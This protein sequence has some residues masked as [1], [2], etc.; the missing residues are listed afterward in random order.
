MNT[1]S[2]FVIGKS[3]RVCQDYSSYGPNFIVVSDGCSGSQDTDFGSRIIAKTFSDYSFNNEIYD[4]DKLI[5][6]CEKKVKLLNLAPMSLDA[7]LLAAYVKDGICTVD[8]YGDGVLVKQ[9]L[10]NTFEVT[11]INY[12][13]D[14]PLYPSYYLNKDRLTGYVELFG[15][16][17]IVKKY[18]LSKNGEVSKSETIDEI[19]GKDDY[20]NHFNTGYYDQFDINKYKSVYLL[21]D[22]AESFYKIKKTETS[23][24]R[25]DVNL[26]DVLISLLDFKAYYGNFISRRLNFFKKDCEKLDW[27]H[28]DDLSLGGMFFGNE[29]EEL[30]QE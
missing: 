21:S 18:I 14:A 10:D 7:T 1:D 9:L 12:P 3:H 19:I 23:K 17:R 5:K 29:Y 4:F 15:L 24:Q 20:F 8:M 2:A 16:N 26:N 27:H 30:E 13:S 6:E 11:I 28:F 22:G 25:V